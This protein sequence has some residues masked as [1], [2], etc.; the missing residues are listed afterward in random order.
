MLLRNGRKSIPRPD[1][2]WGG[3]EEKRSGW[4]RKSGNS[5]LVLRSARDH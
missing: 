4:T 2:F 3:S 5:S 1:D